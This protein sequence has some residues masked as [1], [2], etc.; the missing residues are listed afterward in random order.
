M[1]RPVVGLVLGVIACSVAPGAALGQTPGANGRIAFVTA[2]GKGLSPEFPGPGRVTSVLSDGSDLSLISGKKPRDLDA[3]EY[4]PDGTKIAWVESGKREKDDG[5]YV[6]A[7][8]GTGAKK[9]P[10]TNSWVDG[11]A[12]SPDGKTIVYSD[13]TTGIY[14][15]PSDGSGSRKF[16]QTFPEDG[17]TWRLPKYSPDGATIVVEHDE[18][19]NDERVLKTELWTI[20]ADGSGLA[21]L[22]PGVLPKFSGEPDFSPDGKTLVFNGQTT[23]SKGRW[24]TY[25]VGIDGSNLRPLLN[26]AKGRWLDGPVWSPDGTKIAVS[27]GGTP[28]QDSSLLLLDPVSG[29][30][31]QLSHLTKGWLGQATWQALPAA[32]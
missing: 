21:R 20:K 8:D 27:T 2:T 22:L 7:A 29:A 6:A 10:K 32:Q 3:P 14:S 25:T 23:S 5:V 1:F 11:V 26:A 13:V 12:W 19:A 9:L 24:S 17:G 28:K 30:T 31:T 4:S 16:L 18:F 15:T